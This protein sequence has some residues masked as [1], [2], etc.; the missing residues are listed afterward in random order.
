MFARA[1]AACH[2][3]HGRGFRK[4]GETVRA[5]HDPV[6]LDLTSDQAVRR[7]VIT[8]RSDLGMPSF[9]QA[10]PDDSQWS[11]LTEQD[12][13][14]LMALVASWRQNHAARVKP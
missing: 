4:G 8:G 5:I 12:V 10:R 11:P 13:G 2:G 6:F 3:D 7:Y 1:C 14:D 9:A